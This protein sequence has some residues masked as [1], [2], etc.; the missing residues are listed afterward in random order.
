MTA[1][2]EIE[3]AAVETAMAIAAERGWH[4]VT[5]DAIAAEAGLPAAAVHNH[6]PA[7]AL[8]LGA[9]IRMLDDRVLAEEAPF[10]ELD[11]E[12]DRLFEMLMLRFDAMQP[13]KPALR[14]IARDLPR[15]PLS[16]LANG[17][18]AAL[19][20]AKMLAAAGSDT[21]GLAG[22]ARAHGLLFAWLATVRTWLDDESPDLTRTMATLDRHLRRG[23]RILNAGPRLRRPAGIDPDAAPPEGK[24]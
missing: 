15:D 20:M 18:S 22:V 4:A 16:A 21:R 6:F 7:K 12:R 23:E 9:F 24:L 19:S 2:P 14:Q 17:P 8:I 11:S 10:D 3:T 13:Y 1:A 5:A